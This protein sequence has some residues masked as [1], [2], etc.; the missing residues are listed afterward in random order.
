MPLRAGDFGPSAAFGPA[1][2]R[3]LQRQP[4]FAARRALPTGP[5]SLRRGMDELF[6]GSP[7]VCDACDGVWFDAGEFT[8]WKHEDFMD[9]TKDL[10]ARWKT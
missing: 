8:D 2:R 3:R 5:K 1:F 10:M 6:R 9:V 4:A 7:D